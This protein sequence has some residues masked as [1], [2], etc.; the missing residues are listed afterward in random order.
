[1]DAWFSKGRPALFEALTTICQQI[2]QDL[3]KELQQVASNEGGLKQGATSAHAQPV[4]TAHTRHSASPDPASRA[5]VPV[6]TGHPTE[7]AANGIDENAGDSHDEDTKHW[8]S[9]YTRLN[10]KYNALAENFKKAKEALQKRRHERDQW[11]QHAKFL[12]RKIQEAGTEHGIHI[13]GQSVQEPGVLPQQNGEGEQRPT[14]SLSSDHEDLPGGTHARA[15]PVDGG[16]SEARLASYPA[17]SEPSIK[18]EEP[19]LP[20]LPAQDSAPVKVKEEPSSD[21]AVFVEERALKKRRLSSHAEDLSNHRR[22]KVEHSDHGSSPP[23]ALQGFNFEGSDSIDLGDQS[24]AISTPRRQQQRGPL[25]EHEGQPTGTGTTR[26][27]AT[28]DVA[29]NL[30]NGYVHASAVTPTSVGVQRPQKQPPV[31]SS[32]KSHRRELDRGIAVL[33]ED[34]AAYGQPAQNSPSVVKAKNPA[35]KSR[36][37]TLL[38]TRY[39]EDQGKLDRPSPR[40]RQAPTN[41][42]NALAMPK[43][44]DLPFERN[45]KPSSERPDVPAPATPRPPLADTTNTVLNRAQS[46]ANK[47][48]TRSTLRNKPV[49]ELK[50]DDFKVNPSLNDGHDFAFSEVVRNK[51]DRACLPGCVDMHCC[52]K[53]FRALALSQR[54]NPPLTPTQRQEEQKLLEDYLGDYCYRLAMMSKEERAELWVEA[55]MRELAN[56][57]G[58]H[59][60]RFSRMRSPP[61]FWNADFPSTQELEDNRAEAGKRERQTVQERHREA[62]RPGGRWLFRDE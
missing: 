28:P 5:G 2:D 27:T 61:G 51:D 55:K 23:V 22:V 29:T 3:T 13:L 30:S 34:G 57:Y 37:D 24:P 21:G 62:M 12:E 49:S 52:G 44:R 1:M 8:Q 45:A 48:K 25:S 20:V 6:A 47:K 50:L 38:N 40:G 9:E 43:P 35:T 60:H 19:V 11:I 18:S 15:A 41:T 4:H 10:H 7:Q 31:P 14:R 53:E 58:R 54:P 46:T 36:L 16:G 17:D 59:R 33:A 26:P 39:T 56:K 32:G 42:H